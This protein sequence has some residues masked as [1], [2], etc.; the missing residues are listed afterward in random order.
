M[1]IHLVVNF[2][3]PL[4]NLSNLNERIAYRSWVINLYPSYSDPPSSVEKLPQCSNLQAPLRVIN[5]FLL[6]FDSF[7]A[8]IPI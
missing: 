7:I 2:D 3:A 6:Q 4:I 1:M 5:D 8:E